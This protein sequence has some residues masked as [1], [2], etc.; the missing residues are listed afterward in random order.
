MEIRLQNPKLPGQ[1]T[2]DYSKLS[3]RVQANCKVYHVECNHKFATDIKR[4]AQVAKEANFVSKMWGKHTH[5]TKVVNKLSTPSKIKCLIKVSQHH[6]N[7]QC[8]M[9]VEDVQG[10][11][12][13]DVPVGIY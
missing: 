8:L 11:T 13:L 6:T 2:S 1:D 9:L 5:V 7:Y 3:W 4:L 10:I 12:N